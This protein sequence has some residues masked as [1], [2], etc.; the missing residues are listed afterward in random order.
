MTSYVL[1][2]PRWRK[3]WTDIWGNKLRTM[4]VVLSISVGVFAVGM[5]YSSYLMFQ[6]DLAA[7][8]ETASPANA[9][10]FADPFDE[11][12]VQTIRSIKNIKEAEGR[13]NVNL[14][15]STS[16]GQWC[17][18]V[19]VAIPDY[20]KQK[21]NV[22]RYI[23]GAWPPGDG[24]VLLER[25][26]MTELGVNQGDRI[27]VETSTGR[28]RSMKVTGTVYD[29]SKI[30]S[31]FSGNYYG[32]I[33]MDTLEKL[34]ESRQLDQVDL[35]VE[36][37]VLRGKDTEPIKTVGRQAWRKIEQGDT[38][39]SRLQVHTPGE[40]QM[41]GAINALL[42]LLA[43]LGVLSLLLGTFLLVNTISAILTQQ[44][45]QVGIMKSIGARKDQILRM[46]LS[47]VG[48][49]GLLALLVAAP[50]GALAASMVTSFVS[51]MF[52]FDSGGLELP[53]RVIM[54][55][56]MVAIVVPLLAALGPIWH[57]TGVTVREAI[58]DYGISGIQAKGRMDRWVD[59]GLERLK[60][61]PRPILL[62]LRNTFRRKGRLAL[63]LLTLTV[64]G[65][66]F[67]AV[68]SVRSSLDATLDQALDYFHYDVS[69]QFTQSYRT[70]RIEQ[71]VL[72]VSGVKAVECWGRTSGRVL[73]DEQKES[74]ASKNV[75]I[76]AP[77]VNT[78]MIQ[79]QLIE[80]RWLLPNDE[81]ALVV[82]TEVLKDSPQLKVGEPVVVMVGERK[83]RFTVVGIVQGIL[84]GPIVYASYDWFT[85]AV[86]ETGR[87]RSVQ[88]MAN[89]SDAKEQ[90]ILGRALEEHLKKNSLRIQNVSITWEQKKRI[91][92]QFDIITTFLLIMAVLLAVVGAL[93]LT[94][95]MGINVLE[96]TREIGV[97][98]SIGAS[99]VDIGKVFV[100]EA[101]CIGLLSWTAGM[102]LAVP[103][104]GLLSHQ[105]GILFLKNPL[106]FSF[107]FLGVAIWLGLSTMLSVLASLLPARNAA[108]LSVRDV[109]SYE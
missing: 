46:Y 44:V 6:R 68:F 89:S 8:W 30:P 22:V 66:V 106:A 1:L 102:V 52:N 32:Y 10:L 94:G 81:S 51:G 36:P 82:N 20:F 9:S 57:G 24:D 63:T 12:L 101:L 93:G 3:V 11:E 70:S 13:R 45:R 98:R 15:V 28:K 16:D 50:L 72:Q 4:L 19:L 96:R 42:L 39:V 75:F 90:S 18:L 62:S 83:L 59:I 100:V 47:L 54:L 97:M 56:M 88:I 58:N 41:Q 84:A 2:S 61:L 7:S 43:V 77:P 17:Q 35:V 60:K 79:P 92:S 55:E 14:R 74:E 25:S 108:Q 26:S 31:L 34:D 49:Y 87:A 65:T 38:L 64:A 91:R 48:A 67:M 5:V 29:S 76:L 21:V 27:I 73:E 109:L 23:S 40:H 85:G 71:E 103:V 69:V 104:A 86:Q 95:T 37:W 53:A 105:V 99:S 78:K 80:G 107:S 33:S